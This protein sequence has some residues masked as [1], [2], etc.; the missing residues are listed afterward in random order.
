MDRMK[1][2][3]V[4]ILAVALILMTACAGTSQQPITVTGPDT[5]ILEPTPTLIPGLPTT[6]AETDRQPALPGGELAPA[7]SAGPPTVT[8]PPETPA[9]A[10]PLPAER[11]STARTL[12]AHGN[13]EEAASEYESY[14]TAATLD[15][16]QAT[17][18]LFGLGQA[19][20]QL[21]QYA[22]SAETF[23]QLLVANQNVAGNSLSAAEAPTRTDGFARSIDEAY[24][25]LAQ[26]QQ[27]Q[28]DCSGAVV[29]YEMYLETNLEMT[30]YIQPRI[31]ACHLTLGDRSAAIEAYESA[32]AA[33]SHL[34]TKVALH[35][36]MAQ[37]YLEDGDFPSAIVHYDAILDIAQTERTRGQV[38]YEAGSAELQAGNEDAGYGR[39][40][41]AVND[42]PHA[43][44][45]YLAL[46]ELVKAERAVEDFQRGLVDYYADAYDPAIVAFTRYVEDNPTHR[47]DT[48]LYLAWSYEGLGDTDTAI[49]QIDVYIEANTPQLPTNDVGADSGDPAAVAN[50][51][52][53][54]AKIAERAGRNQ[55]AIDNY[56]TYIQTFPEGEHSSLAAWKMAGLAER[57]G[58]LGLAADRYQAMADSFSGHSDAAEALFRAGHLYWQTGD[59]KKA[60]DSWQQAAESYATQEYGAAALI[61]WLRTTPSAEVEIP[62][63]ALDGF[64]EEYYRLRASHVISDSMPFMAP[65]AVDL[66]YDAAEQ[67]AAEA[68]L[69]QR[70]QLDRNE[71]VRTVDPRLL[72]DGRLIRGEKLWRLG[73]RVQAKRELESLRQEYADDPLWSYQLA[74]L[75]RDLGLYR[76]SIL[77]ANSVVRDSGQSIFEVPRFIGKLVYPT[78]FADLISGEA[79][80]YGY[81]PLLQFALVRQE[82]L[83]E[84]FA[85]SSAAARGL[86]QVIPDT[87]AY[88]AQRLGW[89][90]YDTDDLY[91]PYVGIAFG[92]F[93]LAQQLDAFE[94]D[95]AA[96]LSAY[97]AGP[98]NAARW[99]G[100]A[101]DDIDLYIELVD[102]AETRQYIERIYVG[103]AIYSHLYAN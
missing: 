39:Y 76:S 97:N 13:Y 56:H 20:Y 4:V 16:T 99:Y 46:V 7:T 36:Q 66:G 54:R 84:S 5:A 83:F 6:L 25:F 37:M 55:D 72:E 44:E 42:F 81:D 65:S 80:Q 32:A 74:L 63:F 50:G 48:H 2:L 69:R 1:L 86:S 9:T 94:G 89:A 41:S 78:Y 67:L 101:S 26:T 31:A 33:D 60:A 79:E 61:W 90:D 51:W 47:E 11:L 87:G 8:A 70:L 27:R 93:Y 68:W 95:V 15:T 21:G 52:I 102:F 14:M 58:D 64:D 43:Y 29:S 30:A 34:L 103:Q 53:E 57:M 96:A 3:Q 22:A 18:A 82:S 91:L 45:S 59:T 98:G 62:S 100:E 40:L 17:E 75:F 88:I 92:A 38:T 49:D 12:L 35:Q 77:A 23:G 28:N 71:D 19:Q 24:F 73:Q 10:T 85:A